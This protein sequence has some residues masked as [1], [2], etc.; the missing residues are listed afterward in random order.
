MTTTVKD[1]TPRPDRHDLATLSDAAQDLVAASIADNTKVAYTGALRRLDQALAGE[2]LT[3]ARL[4]DYLA[5]LHA[6]GASPA[7]AAQVVAAVKF[8]AKLN[9]APSPTGPATARVLAGLRRAGA[10]RGRGQVAGV[11]WEHA[12]C[13]ATLATGNGDLAGLRDAAIVAVMSDAMLRVS[14]AAALN[15]DDVGETTVTVRRSK[16]DQE[17]AGAVLF[18]GPATVARI[19]A[20]CAEAGIKEGPLF[21]RIAKGGATVMGRLTARSIRTIVAARSAVTG[22]AGRVSGHSLRVGSAQSLA[23]AGAGLA[24]MQVAGRWASTSM[25]GRYARGELAGRGAVARLRYGR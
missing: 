16:T 15:V 4:A 8:R 21:R 18:I 9:G 6:G 23:S 12:D 25:P 13:A 5:G 10:D 7:V 3:D 1:L 19:K 22:V 14:E 11:R 2:T 17:A 20:W 24:E